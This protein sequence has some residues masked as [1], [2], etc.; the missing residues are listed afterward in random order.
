GLYV[1]L[2]SLFLFIGTGL[3]L[4][5]AQSKMEHLTDTMQATTLN[6]R[7]NPDN[8]AQLKRE[9]PLVFINGKEVDYA[10][11][12]ALNPDKIE[13]INVLKDKAAIAKYGDKAKY[14]VIEVTLKK[15]N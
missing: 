3:T 4:S 6:D 14:G 8:K 13:S 11:L 12:K 2:L 15:D 10:V 5:T 7:K 1:F 9:K